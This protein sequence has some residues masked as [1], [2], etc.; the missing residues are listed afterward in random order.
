MIGKRVNTPNR[1]TTGTLFVEPTISASAS[2]ALRV[3]F[4]AF[5]SLRAVTWND[6]SEETIIN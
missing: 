4:A 3:S 6:N 2:E 1:T 5:V